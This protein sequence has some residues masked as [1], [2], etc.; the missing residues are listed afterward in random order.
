VAKSSAG[1]AGF[2]L[3]GLV[4][5]APWRWGLPV[6]TRLYY[7]DNL[8]AGAML[9]GIFFH[10][11]LA[12]AD[13]VQEFWFIRDAQSTPLLNIFAWL[14][15]SFRMPLFYLIAG[16]FAHFLFKRRGVHGFVRN[17]LIRIVAPFFIF[18]PLMA[19][20]SLGV[21]YFAFNFLTELPPL[22]QHIKAQAEN[23]SGNVGDIGTLH[24]WFLY[25]LALFS[26]I[27]GLFHYYKK[28]WPDPFFRWM[29]SS[30]W[31]LLV[32]P[33]FLVPALYV[34]GAPAP[35]P[36]RLMIKLWPFGY[37]G[38]FFA[39]GWKLLGAEK[40][41][42]RVGAH[43]RLL[44]CSS[45]IAFALYYFLLPPFSFPPAPIESWRRITVSIAQAY[46]A[47]HLTIL[48]LALGKR[49]LNT[50]SVRVRYL[51]DASYWLYLIHLPLVIFAQTLLAETTMSVWEKFA[52][53]SLGPF[54]IGLITY[55]L[56]VRHTPIGDMLNGK[57]YKHL[58]VTQA[59]LR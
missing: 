32:I 41:I 52:I 51:A 37:F 35:S 30:V 4:L 57:R 38:F 2:L 50:E 20:A 21:L 53:A 36:D 47:V 7:L 22:L 15:H 23:H 31:L 10:A 33:L 16:Y 5:A 59:Q 25:Y 44:A 13:P 54:A 14:S 27:G 18:L 43:W 42:D 8:R 28:P 58:G 55:A 11:A 17:R 49:F 46:S 40:Y 6:N 19:V 12:Y 39:F 56:L 48:A 3:I 24:L 9:L 26:A 29:F 34:A 45:A 1:V